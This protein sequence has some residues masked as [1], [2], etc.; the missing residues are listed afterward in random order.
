LI[1]DRKKQPHLFQRKARLPTHFFVGACLFMEKRL[2]TVPEAAC[3]LA[4]SLVTV[5]HWIGR[6]KIP[7]VRLAR[8]AVRLD[9]QTLDKLIELSI[10]K[11]TGEAK[12]DGALQARKDLVARILP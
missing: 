5:Y 2:F 4:I 9:K 8:K 6:R 10:M 7:V 12:K 3:Y 11:T 1:E